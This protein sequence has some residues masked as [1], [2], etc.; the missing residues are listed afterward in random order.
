MNWRHTSHAW[1]R[2]HRDPL[3]PYGLALFF[4]E[5]FVAPSQEDYH[6][7]PDGS[8]PQM[9]GLRTA[10]R[11]FPAGAEFSYLPRVIYDFGRAVI[12]YRRDGRD[13]LHLADRV[14]PLEPGS[15]YIGAGISSLDTPA[16]SWAEATRQVPNAMSIPGTCY[17]HLID[18]TTLLCHRGG[19]HEYDRIT[20]TCSTTVAENR[21]QVVPALASRDDLVPIVEQLDGLNRTVVEGTPW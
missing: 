20:I 13:V 8:V 4:I 5:P 19:S 10:T 16:A 17:A 15:V 1:D 14:E 3:S 21:C 9:G 12:R 11:L 6:N 2:R 7:Y 18:A